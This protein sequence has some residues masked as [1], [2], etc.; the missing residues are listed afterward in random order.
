MPT[1]LRLFAAL[2]ALVLLAPAELRA[3]ILYVS[4]SQNDSV[5]QLNTAMTAGTSGI[6]NPIAVNNL[7]TGGTTPSPEGV[8]LDASGN[9]YVADAA[10]SVIYKFTRNPGGGFLGA[11]TFTQSIYAQGASLST[12]FGIAFDGSGNL[13]VANANNGSVSRISADGHDAAQGGTVIVAAGSLFLPQ[14]LTVGS[15]GFLYVAQNLQN[16]GNSTPP[17]VNVYSNITGSGSATSVG[18]I[19]TAT[20]GGNP[21]HP[22]GLAFQG[23]N[24][25]ISEFLNLSASLVVQ[26]PIGANGLATGTSNT[27]YGGTTQLKNPVGLAFDQ[28]GNLYVADTGATSPPNPGHLVS[29]IA[30]NGGSG[31]SSTPFAFGFGNPQFISAF[32]PQVA[33]TPEPSS[34]ALLGLAASAMAGYGWWG[35]RRRRLAEAT[36]ATAPTAETAQEE[37]IIL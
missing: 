31:G 15:N 14:G 30:P 32:V 23:S 29:Q 25:Y 22:Y 8:A 21:Y 18:A 20:S 1:L 36:A 7:V 12:P 11:G 13:Y 27:N 10:N 37:G 28:A 6:L 2:A 26:Q 9:L 24:L 5:Y 17:Q 19:A 16:T 3:D 35:K 4:D 33:G 34:L